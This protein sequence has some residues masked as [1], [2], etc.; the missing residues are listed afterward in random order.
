M[1]RRVLAQARRARKNARVPPREIPDPI[2]WLLVAAC[3]LSLFLWLFALGLLAFRLFAAGFDRAA[4]A[5]ALLVVVTGWAAPLYALREIGRF[6]S[7]EGTLRPESTACSIGI[8]LSS[9]AFLAALILALAWAI[10]RN[11]RLAPSGVAVGVGL[12]GLVMQG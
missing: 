6:V 2:G 7:W 1:S 9:S 11:R 8:T 10:G 5:S 4:K 3:I 12:V